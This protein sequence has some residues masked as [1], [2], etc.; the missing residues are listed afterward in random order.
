[1]F[2]VPSLPSKKEC[3]VPYFIHSTFLNYLWKAKPSWLKQ[4]IWRVLEIPILEVKTKEFL[5]YHDGFDSRLCQ[6]GSPCLE[7]KKR[8]VGE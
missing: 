6:S 1:M 8:S 2:F 4:M 5:H 7:S 3:F